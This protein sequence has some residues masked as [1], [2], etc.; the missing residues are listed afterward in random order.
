[1]A[2]VMAPESARWPQERWA[3]LAVRMRRARTAR[4]AVALWVVTV[5]VVGG[6]AA[7]AVTTG[8]DPRR[9]GVFAAVAVLVGAVA[10]V[11]SRRLVQAPLYGTTGRARASV[12]FHV[13]QLHDPDIRRDTPALLHELRLV[14]R[15]LVRVRRAEP[16]GSDRWWLLEDYQQ[17]VDAAAEAL[18]E[19]LTG[20]ALDVLTGLHDVVSRLRPAG[21][22]KAG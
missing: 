22:D 20:S 15:A 10:A 5:G 17:Q 18:G 2:T 12:V 9:T 14:S 8:G 6:F 4:W 7:V 3:A 19:H 11:V 16:P 21:T 1:M 13:V